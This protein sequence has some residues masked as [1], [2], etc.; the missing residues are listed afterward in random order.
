M[1]DLYDYFSQRQCIRCNMTNLVI[2]H[3]SGD[4]ICSNCGEIISDRIINT[5]CEEIVYADDHEAGKLTRT[6]GFGESLGSNET[7]LIGGLENQKEALERAQKAGID[8]KEHSVLG[9][10]FIVNEL[11]AKM[12]LTSKIKVS[13]SLS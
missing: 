4:V 1:V 3:C 13:I 5:A 9:H 7:L 12:N 8:R 11:C 2:D 10:L 6:S